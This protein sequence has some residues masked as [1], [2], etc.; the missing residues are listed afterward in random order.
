L[1]YRGFSLNILVAL[2]VYGGMDEAA[3]M[4]RYGGGQG[5]DWL[6]R[7]R[8]EGLESFKLVRTVPGGVRLASRGAGLLGYLGIL[9]KR[10][11]NLGPGG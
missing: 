11:L 6:L 10:T 7:R 8:I 9:F 5:A 3:L 2:D 4:R 1:L